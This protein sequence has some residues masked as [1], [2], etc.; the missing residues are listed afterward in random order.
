MMDDKTAEQVKFFM[1]AIYCIEVGGQLDKAWSG[2]LAGMQVVVRRKG[3]QASVSTLT[4]RIR[5][6]A[7]LAGLL[8]SLYEMHL[9]ILKVEA[10]EIIP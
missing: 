8:N 9:P 10:R 7:E 4:G 6:Q 1:P 2:R 3:N 5:D